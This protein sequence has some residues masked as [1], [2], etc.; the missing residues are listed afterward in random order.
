MKNQL[1]YI[2]NLLKWNSK[3]LVHT[4]KKVKNLKFKKLYV[5]MSLERQVP[6]S[7]GGGSEIWSHGFRKRRETQKDFAE[8]AHMIWW[9]ARPISIG[10]ASRPEIQA[11]FLYG[12]LEA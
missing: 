8:L 10:Q 2:F 7:I 3:L 1:D 9:V 11:E 6:P 12:S 4:H 5:F